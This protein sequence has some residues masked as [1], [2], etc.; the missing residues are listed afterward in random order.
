MSPISPE[1]AATQE[2][3]D[4]GSS[5]G[6]GGEEEK[7]ERGGRMRER[8]DQNADPV[9]PLEEEGAQLPTGGT[10]GSAL[11]GGRREFACC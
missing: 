6:G 2:S 10:G 1:D 5:G 9:S 7:K 8:R 11:K 4:G 3:H